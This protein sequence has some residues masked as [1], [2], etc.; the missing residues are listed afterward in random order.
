LAHRLVQG[1]DLWLNLPRAPLEACGT[2]GMKAA[3]NGVP[4]LSILDGWWH[5]GFDGH[6]GWALPARGAAA[7]TDKADAEELY[8]LLEQQV[9]PL[10]YSRD[11]RGVPLGWTARMKHALH[12]AG[13]RF[14]ADRMVR[15]YV[16]DAYAPAMRGSLAD[17]DPP[18]A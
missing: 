17:D 15:D 2:S 1:V 5:E 16:A 6:N 11:S 4:Q 10:Y 13:A 12:I 7:D 18:S 9:V 8:L 3:L 14:T